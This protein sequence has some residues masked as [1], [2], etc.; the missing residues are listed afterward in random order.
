MLYLGANQDAFR[1]ASAV[2]IG[3]GH[4]M[5]YAV[6]TERQS[7]AA[8]ARGTV[9]YARASSPSAGRAKAAFSDAE[10]AAAKPVEKDPAS[11]A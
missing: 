10:R 2:G 4:A 6:G 3:A 8:A 5:A 1:E 9:Q 11:K 7:F